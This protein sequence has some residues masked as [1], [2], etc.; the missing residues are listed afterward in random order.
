MDGY[1]SKITNR[2]GCR[3]SFGPGALDGGSLAPASRAF[4]ARNHR[5]PLLRL[6]PK[7]TVCLRC[8]HS[9]R[10]AAYR[11]ITSTLSELFGGRPTHPLV[12]LYL[13]GRCDSWILVQ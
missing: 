2:D 5:K 4:L 8:P 13:P 3:V 12:C 10:S 11:D 1:T 6:A 7:V 9:Y